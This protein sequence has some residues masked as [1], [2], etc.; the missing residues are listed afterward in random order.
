L[1]AYKTE[2]H[3]H[4]AEVSPCG[5]I[6]ARWGIRL[7]KKLGYHTV[8][9]TDHFSK[10]YFEMLGRLSWKR[11]VDC[12]LRGYRIARREGE[13]QGVRVILGMEYDLPDTRDDILIYGF[14]EAFLYANE[15]LYLLKADALRHKALENNL[16]LIQAHPFRKKITR[17]YDEL[18]EG[19]E[20]FNG[21]P[22]HDSNNPKA[23]AYA[24]ERRWIALSGSDFHRRE[25]AGTGGVF[26]PSI[27]ENSLELAGII[28][29]VRTPGRIERSVIHKP[30]FLEKLLH[31]LK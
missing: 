28:R 8:V 18:V 23:L 20:V 3:L 19:L 17:V 4:T 11:K 1:E 13:K 7:Y 9:V 31:R 24:M 27:P 29:S 10:R 26:L 25:D 12:F 16:L 22:R 15:N 6:P 5:R 2:L 30:T 21:N 14:D